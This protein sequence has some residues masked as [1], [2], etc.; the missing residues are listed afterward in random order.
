MSEHRTIPAGYQSEHPS[1]PVEV[2]RAYRETAKRE[3]F[4]YYPTPYWMANLLFD[5]LEHDGL[6]VGHSG[7]KVLEPC[8]GDGRIVG[9]LRARYGDVATIKTNDLD[10]GW[11]ADT[12]EDAGD[13]LSGFWLF[14]AD[15]II[16]N[17]P[18]AAADRIVPRALCF[19]PNVAML[20]RITWLEPVA[21]RAD[22]LRR[23]PPTKLIV[24]PRFSFRANGKTDSAPAAWMIWSSLVTPGVVVEA[25]PAGNDAAPGLDLE[26]VNAEEEAAE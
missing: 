22:F 26:D 2:E 3:D 25:T 16:T 11:P 15:W 17:P 4:D 13:G 14:P 6:F 21:T 5:N 19:A 12:H 10:P 7:V 23:H 8:V 18:F 1:L 20:L 9:A 24:M